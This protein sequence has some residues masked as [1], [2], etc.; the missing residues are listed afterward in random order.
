ML[1]TRRKRMVSF[2]QCPPWV[3]RMR[4][5][6]QGMIEGYERALN[7][8][9]KLP[10]TKQEASDFPIILNMNIVVE[11]SRER[12]GS[13]EFV[14]NKFEKAGYITEDCRLVGGG[15]PDFIFRKNNEEI[16]IEVKSES[17]G[18]SMSQA[19]WILQNPSKK[20]ILYYVDEV[21]N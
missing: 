1:S 18:L 15:H 2:N 11:K 16:Y 14:K 7:V 17:Y 5:R 12:I 9:R 3:A 13:E 10:K 4:G 21:G 8:Q 19:R 6:K 20:V